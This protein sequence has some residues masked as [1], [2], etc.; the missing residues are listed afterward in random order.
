MDFAVYITT[1]PTRKVIYTGATNNLPRR[2]TEHYLER[3][4]PKAFAG[5]NYCYNLVYYDVFPT[6]MEAIVAE[7]RIKGK[8]RN[9]KEE[10]INSFN[11]M[12]KFLNREIVGE[13]P[14][15]KILEDP[16]FQKYLE[17]FK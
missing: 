12:W 6:M 11:P 5:K 16:Y 3:G 9:W 13:W 17:K 1:N 4:K 15:N 2:V 10:L 14:P 7:K 8:S